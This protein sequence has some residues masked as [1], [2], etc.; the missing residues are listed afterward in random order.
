MKAAVAS[1]YGSPDVVSIENVEE[2]TPRDDQ[3]LIEVHATTISAGDARVRAHRVPSGFGWLTRLLFG[4]TRLRHPILGTECAGVV[5]A[6]GAKVTRWRPGDE[7]FALTGMRM[8]GHAELCVIDETSA[9][10]RKPAGLSFE[11]SAALAFGGVTA[12]DFLRRSGV[13]PG[14]RVLINGAS[15]AVGVAAVQIAKARGAHVTAV[16][17]AANAALVRSLGADDHID[18][19]KSDFCDLA[20]RATFDV[21]MDAVGNAG[22]PRSKRALAPKG[23]LLLVVADLW[24]MLATP[25]VN[26]TTKHRVLSGP[27][28]ETHEDVAELA[29]MVEAGQLRPVIDKTFA[30]DEIRA[31]HQRADSGRKRGNVVVKVRA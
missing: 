9:V 20:D 10:A 1:A 3:I 4:F 26:V 16:C 21:I 14:E 22:Y 11:E 18:Y 23:R 17:S 2:P 31:A 30:F 29:A 6:V 28:P 8:G 7:V 25:W 13:A 15:G 5:R 12:L 27:S 24:Q 19:A